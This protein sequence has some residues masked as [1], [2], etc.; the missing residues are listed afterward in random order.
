[1]LAAPAFG[2]LLPSGPFGWA[3]PFITMNFENSVA[4][5]AARFQSRRRRSASAASV[6]DS[7]PYDDVDLLAGHRAP[8]PVRRD[9]SGRPFCVMRCPVDFLPKMPS[10]VDIRWACKTNANG[11]FET[12]QPA[13]RMSDYRV[14]RKIPPEAY[15][16]TQLTLSGPCRAVEAVGPSNP[17]AA[18]TWHPACMSFLAEGCS[19][20]DGTTERP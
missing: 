9:R 6:H 11:T 18:L 14:E 3:C 19:G 15:G 12:Y 8:H 16:T 10:K 17:Q 20:A 1:M 5:W 4:D 13:R 7:S 2:T